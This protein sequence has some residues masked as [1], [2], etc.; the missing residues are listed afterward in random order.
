LL[1]DDEDVAALAA[2][3]CEN[4]WIGAESGS[5]KVLDAMDKGTT[6]EQIH[7][8]ATDEKAWH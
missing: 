6:V 2:S 3:G 5:Q 1:L 7:G 4:V 8:H